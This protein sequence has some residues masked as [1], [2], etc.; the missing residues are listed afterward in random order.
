[1]AKA[2][3]TNT[4]RAAAA[5][6]APAPV[7]VEP[8]FV[9]KELQTSA[10]DAVKLAYGSMTLPP[11][12]FLNLFSKVGE[13]YMKFVA[14]RMAAQAERLSTLSKCANAEEFAKA[15][16]T[17]FGKAAQ[18]YAEQFDRMAEKTHDAAAATKAGDSKGA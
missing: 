1:M 6:A 9:V 7:K 10:D 13:E 3:R 11:A 14:Q 18:D 4:P 12:Q 16:M 17:F 15:E 2:P 5:G 8:D